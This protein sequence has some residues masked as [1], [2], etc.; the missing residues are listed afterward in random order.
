MKVVAVKCQSWTMRL[1]MLLF[2]IFMSLV[3]VFICSLVYQGD[4][5]IPDYPQWTQLYASIGL[6]IGSIGVLLVSFFRDEIV[7]RFLLMYN[8]FYIFLFVVAVLLKAPNFPAIYGLELILLSVF[9]G[10][11]MYSP[12]GFIGKQYKNRSYMVYSSVSL[13]GMLACLFALYSLKDWD[14]GLFLIQYWFL[15]KTVLFFF[16]EE[17]N[18]SIALRIVSILFSFSFWIV[19][20]YGVSLLYSSSSI[21]LNY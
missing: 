16:D 6:F 10:T 5:A 13:F 11:M 1:W 12:F 4:N 8:C 17:K 3:S 21:S 7:N 9:V 18:S 19:V 20:C 2:P 14:H 15:R